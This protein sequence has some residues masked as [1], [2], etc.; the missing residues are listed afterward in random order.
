MQNPN[1]TTK[2]MKDLLSQAFMALE[3]RWSSSQSLLCQEKERER[4]R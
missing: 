1:T 4:E 3:R 2:A